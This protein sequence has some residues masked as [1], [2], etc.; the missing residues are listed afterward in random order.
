V[1]E[2]ACPAKVALANTYMRAVHQ[3][4]GDVDGAELPPKPAPMTDTDSES[5]PSSSLPTAQPD[6]KQPLV[7]AAEMPLAGANPEGAI[8]MSASYAAGTVG[9]S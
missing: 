5:A 6:A 3:T 4:D 8:L 9:I 1:L 2:G 7:D